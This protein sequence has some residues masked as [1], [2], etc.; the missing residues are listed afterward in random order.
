MI[1]FFFIVFVRI[2]TQIKSRDEHC[3]QVRH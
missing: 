2:S 3:C 1:S